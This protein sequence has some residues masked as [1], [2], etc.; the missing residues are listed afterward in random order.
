MPFDVTSFTETAP[1]LSRP[2][3]AGLSYALRHRETWPEKFRWYYGHCPTC[4]MGLAVV[5]WNQI[6]EPSTDETAKAFGIYENT[7]AKLFL[8]LPDNINVPLWNITPDHVADAIDE[9]LA[10]R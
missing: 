6:E 1:D 10:G 4:A 3:L 8:Y 9:Y 2:S 5:L 7:A